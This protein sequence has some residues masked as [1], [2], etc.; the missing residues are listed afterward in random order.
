MCVYKKKHNLCL[1]MSLILVIWIVFGYKSQ[2]KNEDIS[3]LFKR[4][5]SVFLREGIFF[6]IIDIKK[7]KN[8]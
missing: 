1:T 4:T 3:H 7:D 5:I 8:Y 2:S 6:K